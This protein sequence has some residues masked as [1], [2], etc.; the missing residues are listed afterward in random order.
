[1]IKGKI[2][3]LLVTSMRVIILININLKNANKQNWHIRYNNYYITDK[4]ENSNEDYNANNNDN[5][6]DLKNYNN[7]VH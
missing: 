5:E 2:W 1:M 3:I 6:N 7:R 4:D